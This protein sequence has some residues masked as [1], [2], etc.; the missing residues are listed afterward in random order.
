MTLPSFSLAAGDSSVENHGIILFMR[1]HDKIV[2]HIFIFL[3]SMARLARTMKNNPM[4]KNKAFVEACSRMDTQ[5][6]PKT[7]PRLIKIKHQSKAP[8]YAKLQNLR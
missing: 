4:R 6:F 3:K 8:E 1:K 7:K 2:N 5:L